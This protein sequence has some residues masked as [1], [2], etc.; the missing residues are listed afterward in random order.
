MNIHL[1]KGTSK[2]WAKIKIVS[3]GMEYNYSNL[4]LLSMVEKGLQS[5]QEISLD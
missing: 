4:W 1:E 2:D 3:Q 5:F